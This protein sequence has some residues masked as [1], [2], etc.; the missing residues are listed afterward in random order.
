M[1]STSIYGSQ[2]AR[3]FS[4][5]CGSVVQYIVKET[6]ATYKPREISLG[7]CGGTFC[8]V[9]RYS[10]K[11]EYSFD[12]RSAGRD[13]IAKANPIN[14]RAEVVLESELRTE[15]GSV[16]NRRAEVVLESELRTEAGSV[17]N[18]RAEAV[19]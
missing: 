3:P 10:E 8:V 9:H 2:T 19:L 17:K 16:K 14:K 12:Y 13:A 5:C 15:T 11:H 18:R 6:K 7:R 4:R 1:E